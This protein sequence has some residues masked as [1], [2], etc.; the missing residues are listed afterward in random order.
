MDISQ[1]YSEF[2]TSSSKCSFLVN[3]ILILCIADFFMLYVFLILI[4]FFTFCESCILMNAYDSQM[5]VRSVKTSN[6]I[7]SCYLVISGYIFCMFA[8]F[9]GLYEKNCKVECDFLKLF[10]KILIYGK[11]F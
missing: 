11:F 9:K 3:V 1:I 10:I 7:T 8:L 4:F 5:Q 2:K 6:K